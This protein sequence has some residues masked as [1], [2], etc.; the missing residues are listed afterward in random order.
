MT[1]EEFRE[2]MTE[3]Q[4]A[5][6]DIDRATALTRLSDSVD[7]LFQDNTTLNDKVTALTKDVAKYS[8]LNQDLMIK[9]GVV[10][11]PTQ[12]SSEEEEPP[13]KLSFDDITF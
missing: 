2:L 10:N 1:R 8:Q 11:S 12:S 9:V 6:S 7:T 4:S 13:A 5:E 3:L